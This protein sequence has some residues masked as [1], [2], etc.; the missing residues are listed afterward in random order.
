MILINISSW[1]VS[2]FSLFVF[3]ENNEPINFFT[4]SKFTD[5]CAFLH[6]MTSHDLSVNRNLW[7]FFTTM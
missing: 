7:F 2:S 1:N 4:V 5:T 6:G 3:G